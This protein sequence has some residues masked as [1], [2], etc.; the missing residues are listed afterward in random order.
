MTVKEL[1][2]KLKKYPPNLHVLV[3]TNDGSASVMDDFDSISI[4]KGALV[5][6]NESVSKFP[7]KIPNPLC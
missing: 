7:D 2:K 3:H 5:L 4:I 6:S 1:I